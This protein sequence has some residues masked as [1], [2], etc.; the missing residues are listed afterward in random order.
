MLPYAFSALTMSA[1]GLA[2]KEMIT[3][4]SHQFECEGVRNG[5]EQP[6]Y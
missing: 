5:T 4:I 1:V 6:D 3:E 2:A